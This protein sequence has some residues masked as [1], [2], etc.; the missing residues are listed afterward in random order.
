MKKALILVIV[1]LIV[2]VGLSSA[3]RAYADYE[4]PTMFRGNPMRTG[5][6]EVEG[7]KSSGLKWE[8]R[9]DTHITSSPIF[10][11]KGI[12]YFAS[13]D[14]I[15]VGLS[16]EKGITAFSLSLGEKIDS[17]PA[18]YNNRIFI[19][20]GN[21][22]YLYSFS[23]TSA[24]RKWRIYKHDDFHSS[25]LIAN[26]T[27]YIGCDDGYMVAKDLTNDR[28]E[29]KWEYNVGSPV[30]SSPA[31]TGSKVFFGTDNGHLY[32]LT[33]TGQLLWKT[34][35]GGKIRAT[36]LISGSYLY[37]GSSNGS[38]YKMTLGGDVVK[39][40]KTGGDIYSSAALMSDGSIVVGSYDGYVYIFS[41]EL[42]LLYKFNAGG[43]I[44]SSPCV[45]VDDTIYVG[46][47]D[48]ILYAITNEGEKIFDFEA[49]APIYSSPSIGV[50]GTLYFGDDKGWIYAIGSQTGI[51]TVLA[52]LD[53]AEYLIE[54]PKTYY[55]KGKSYKVMNAPVGEYTITY[56]DISGYNTPESV[57]LELKA[58]SSIHF[59]GTYEKAVPILSAIVVT[60]N[61]DDATFVIT[62]LAEYAGFGKSFTI[63]NVPAG[64]YIIKFNDV[65][66]YKTPESIEKEV[67][68]GD[69]VTFTGIYEKLPE[70][71]ETEIVLQIDNAYMMVNGVVEEVDPGRG[72]V[73]TIIA[74]WG[75][76]VLPIRTIVET[77]GGEI[78]WN[79][80]ERKVTILFKDTIIN[81]WIGKN[82]AQVNDEY[83]L[84]DSKNPDVSPVIIN[85]R[86]MVPI[87]FVAETLGC[88]VEWDPD[89]RTVTITYIE[90]A[91]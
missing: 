18:I 74:K 84:I 88:T 82:T 58:N 26:D 1:L 62:G 37:V 81:L 80:N 3:Q 53:E 51:I 69:I 14:G 63:K 4:V 35:L 41:D 23:L 64:I 34:L 48:G 57:T 27:L 12:V 47:L 49:R 39:T 79:G 17:T 42:T 77:L 85:S 54:G 22:P 32:C 76:T 52:N 40:F 78:L 9:I 2:C 65:T 19:A 28:N 10:D 38:F 6:V 31:Y 86:T 75:R 5:R 21:P 16:P 67:K 43:Q 90:P 50:D 11:D 8:H 66:G 73:P 46:T 13:Y 72:T 15:V 59:E 45:A 30:Y 91:G 56:K 24:A 60:T 61:L 29:F 83:F 44:Y 7:P 68:E 55:G 87:R 70:A 33:D 36:P 71:K 25:F 89:T 20:G